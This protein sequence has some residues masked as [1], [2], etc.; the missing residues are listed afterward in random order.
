VGNQ[1]SRGR[2]HL[3]DIHGGRWTNL[4]AAGHDLR[5]KSDTWI[6]IADPDGNVLAFESR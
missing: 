5:S 6:Q 2:L 1:A 4:P 3:L